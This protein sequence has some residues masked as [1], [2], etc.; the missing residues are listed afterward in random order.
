MM[1]ATATAMATAMAQRDNQ[2]ACKEQEVP[3]DDGSL[4][5]SGGNERAG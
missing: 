3:A 5:R 2:P 1:T 4:T